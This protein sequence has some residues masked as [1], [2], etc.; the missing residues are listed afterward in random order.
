MFH[1]FTLKI[2]VQKILCKNRRRMKHCS[3]ALFGACVASD[4]I[5]C[6]CAR[7]CH[8][9][10]SCYR[11]HEVETPHSNKPQHY[12]CSPLITDDTWGHFKDRGVGG[13]TGLSWRGINFFFFIFTFW[14]IN[15]EKKCTISFGSIT[16]QMRNWNGFPH[17]T[18]PKKDASGLW[19]CAPAA[20]FHSTNTHA[21]RDVLRARAHPVSKC[22]VI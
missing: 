3:G 17:K 5:S 13:G 22:M 8:I 7:V 12:P 20:H 14:C 9:D 21:R 4:G 19:I 10:A 16:H 11:S 2:H 1:F 6:K 18:K 15:Y